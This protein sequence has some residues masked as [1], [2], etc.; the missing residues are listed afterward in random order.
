MGALLKMIVGVGFNPLYLLIAAAVLFGAGAVSGFGGGWTLQG[1]KLGKELATSQG[2]AKSLTLR[3]DTLVAANKQCGV[4]VA[5]VKAAVKGI[6]DDAKKVN[7]TAVAA[8]EKV[9]G[10]A[11]H[12][13]RKA[14]EALNRP[15]VPPAE[16]CTALQKEATAYAAARRGLRMDTTL[17]GKP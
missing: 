17:K 12:H 5:D 9:A 15:P 11:D 3:N 16:W 13:Q 4:N 1:W 6:A 2:E 14:T 10:K 8:M 7:D